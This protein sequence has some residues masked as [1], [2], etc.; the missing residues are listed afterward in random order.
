MIMKKAIL[1]GL[2]LVLSQSVLAYVFDGTI[3]GQGVPVANA[4]VQILSIPGNIPQGNTLTDSNGYYSITTPDNPGLYTVQV[5][6]TGPY[7]G[8]SWTG[9]ATAGKT[10]NFSLV[11]I[12]SVTVSGIIED[13][14]SNPLPGAMIRVYDTLGNLIKDTNTNGAGNYSLTIGDNYNYIV[15]AHLS[16]FD[17]TT[18]SITASGSD[19]TLDFILLDSSSTYTVSGT[20]TGQGAS[21]E[22]AVVSVLS[23]P[24]NILQGSASTNSNGDYTITMPDTSGLYTVKVDLISPY[25]GDSWTGTINSSTTKDFDLIPIS[26]I[27]VSGYVRNELGA[28]VP[29]ARVQFFIGTDM[30]KDVLVDSNTG[31]YT[32]TVGDSITYTAEASA[33]TYYSDSNTFA[34]S[35]TDKNIDFVLAL[36]EDADSDGYMNVVCGGLDCDDSNPNV[37]PGAI[38]QCN[39]IDDD[40]DGEIDEGFNLNTNVNHCGS[41]GNAC[42]LPHATAKCVLGVCRIAACNSNYSNQNGIDSDGCE[43]RKT[44]TSGS[45]GSGGTYTPPSDNNEDGQGEDSSGEQ[46]NTDTN[47]GLEDQNNSVN[48]LEA[49]NNNIIGYA[50][51]AQKPA[52][53][54][55]SPTGFIFLGVS[56]TIWW[57]IGLIASLLMI[58][59]YVLL[60]KRK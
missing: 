23:I 41:C 42:S 45:S 56:G 25:A 34:A 52:G 29:T 38:E 24:G 51:P 60:R 36:C 31:Y 7:A 40:C 13:N 59:G 8:D 18:K 53:E 5:S 9:M 21:L 4:P 39:N 44:N 22:N 20:V 54:E 16:P 17:P 11:T 33:P 28:I 1:L 10:T 12:A 50:P 35:G 46:G 32:I 49:G 14:S 37:F 3:T 57:V 15:E 19:I 48:G 27:T 47:A 55:L 30:V 58:S 6:A 2:I 43:K 26:T